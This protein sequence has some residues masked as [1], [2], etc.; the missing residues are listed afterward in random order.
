M[1]ALSIRQPYAWLILY[2]GKDVENR[3]WKTNYRGQ[4]LIHASKE[5]DYDAIA[6]MTSCP[7]FANDIVAR[8]PF[9]SHDYDKGGIVGTVE[10]VD[11]V[12]AM[13]SPWFGGPYGFV[14]RNPKPLPFFPCK[15]RLGFFEIA[16]GGE[17]KE[18]A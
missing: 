6:W 15:G 9:W 10:I 13:N 14:L 8:L 3:K 16:C 1:K 2:G 12:T 17:H 5:F 7:A 18:I 4:I 11:C